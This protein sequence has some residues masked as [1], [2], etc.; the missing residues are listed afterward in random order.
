MKLGADATTC[1]CGLGSSVRHSPSPRCGATLT[2]GANFAHLVN[3]PRLYGQTWDTAVDLQFEGIPS[4]IEHQLAHRPGLT[5]LTLGVHGNI[6]IRGSVVPAVGLAAEVGPLLAPVILEGRVPR[7]RDELALGTSTLRRLHL[8]VGD[9]VATTVNGRRT[10]LHIVGRAV[11]PHFGQG[12]FAATDLGEGA[13]L[14]AK[15]LS[16]PASSAQIALMRFIPGSMHN[17]DVTE[18]ERSL[19]GYCRGIDQST[20]L[21]SNQ[22]PSD[23]ADLVRVEK[24]P[25]VLALVLGVFGIAVLAQLVVLYCRRRRHDLA[26]LKTLGAIRR[27]VFAITWWQTS[28][29]AGVSLLIGLP[30]GIAVGRWI[31]NLFAANVGVVTDAT[32]PTWTILLLVPVLVVVANLVAVVPGRR[33]ASLHPAEVLRSE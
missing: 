15:A 28:A 2:F 9:D 33:S 1:L 20:C 25:F 6:A 10:S 30:L 29:L 18:T 11:F 26:V 12:S 3:T 23:I 31:W 7:T 8:Q 22:R 21:V 14:T 27:Q 17:R 24:T 4:G 19:T 16:P 32:I 5:A 13:L